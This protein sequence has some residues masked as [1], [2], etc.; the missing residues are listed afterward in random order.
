MEA[1]DILTGEVLE[2][3]PRFFTAYQRPVFDSSEAGD[4]RTIT[5]MAYVPPQV[6]INEMMEAGRRLAAE[7]RLRFDSSELNVDDPDGDM[8]EDPTRAPGVDLVDVSRAQMALNRRLA[9]R[10][11]ALRAERKAAEDAKQA[12]GRRSEDRGNQ[13]ASDESVPEPEAGPEVH[14]KG[15]KA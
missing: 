5:E 11:A 3:A 1:F 12:A 14:P 13:Q 7:R 10:R 9:A 4:P 15:K 8:P 2:V 6:R